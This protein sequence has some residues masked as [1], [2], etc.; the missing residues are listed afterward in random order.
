MKSLLTVFIVATIAV[1]FISCQIRTSYVKSYYGLVNEQ[2]VL[3]ET[4]DIA[5][6][7]R[8]TE[9]GLPEDTTGEICNMLMKSLPDIYGKYVGSGTF[10]RHKGK[11][12]VLTAEHVC[13]PDEAPDKV[14]KGAI[15]I[16][17]SKSSSITVRSGKFKAEATIVRKKK[18]QRSGSV[19]S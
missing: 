13:F 9:K 10:I 2:T 6:A 17:V 5:K 19:Y 1:L 16:Y 14:E 15:T 7:T 8:C 11:I 12:R 18:G 3:V 4:V